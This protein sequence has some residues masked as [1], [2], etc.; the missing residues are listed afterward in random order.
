MKK[1]LTIAAALMLAAGA[2][3]AKW[4]IF[5][6]GGGEI[7]LR[8]LT[9]NG[10]SADEAGRKMV[11]YRE[12]LGPDGLVRI[13]GRAQTGRNKVGGVRVSL[14]DK[15]TWQDAKVAD[16][17]TFEYAFKPEEG[18][19]YVLLVEVTDTA[20]KTNKVD[21]TRKE[22]E[23]SGE[24]I[25]AGIR[26]ALDAMFDAYSKE[27]LAAFMAHV[28]DDFAG[29]KILLERA[30]KRDFD[31]L[32]G[33]NIRYT[34]N[35]I[36]AGASGRVFVSIT[37]N[38]FVV[39]NKTGASNTDNGSTEFVFTMKEGRPLLY[40]M[41]QPLMFGLSDAENVATGTVLGGGGEALV[42]DD[43]GNLGGSY[44][45]VTV[46]DADGVFSYDMDTQTSD[47]S[48]TFTGCGGTYSGQI[49]F[50]LAG[51][52]IYS[53]TGDEIAQIPGKNITTVTAAD[54]QA[55]TDNCMSNNDNVGKTYGVKSG[56]ALY[57]VEV[58]SISGSGP[59]SVTF[60]F[61]KF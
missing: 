33:I 34:L 40:S 52:S 22:L 41:K 30:V 27:R 7:G 36:A 57:A 55:I 3:Q 44:T 48:P 25:Q 19:K 61:R 32:S 26:A 12:T 10:A 46:S 24:K 20:G 37:Y 1:I 9:V 31:S 2:A 53:G 59:Y 45:Q 42:L 29:D 4:W 56:G 49:T 15:A 51:P 35:N 50:S 6:K 21:D 11:I 17:G 54:V 13:Q 38:R 43:G 8:Y 14:D 18:K 39:V 23:L 5:G 47:A 16:N 60:K 28:G 58:V